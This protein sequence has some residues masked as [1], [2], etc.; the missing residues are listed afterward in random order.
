MTNPK[1]AKDHAMTASRLRREGRA[2]AGV[3]FALLLGPGWAAAG[4]HYYDGSQQ[5]PITRQADLVAGFA[6]GARRDAVASAYAGAVALPG[7]GDS[8]VRIY[9]L[10]Q[11][12]ARS[13]DRAA[14]PAA[15][16]SPV[17]REG[18]SPAG[19]LMAL[20]GGVLVKFKPDWTRPQIDTWL[21][22]RG[23]AVER[24]L[25]MDGNWFR[26]GT[27]AGDAS[28]KTANEIYESGAVLAAV[29]N[30]WKQTHT[31]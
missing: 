11:V 18:N 5:R 22:A 19:R 7:V 8:L 3:V 27:P 29:P 30:W 13:T 21:A 26:V 25:A 10:P 2:L 15:A 17:Y 23:L 16:V 14:A 1:T 4:E 20:P 28:L 24:K 9:R 12:G 6:Q 31:R